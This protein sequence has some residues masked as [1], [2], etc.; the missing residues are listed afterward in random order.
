MRYIRLLH[1]NHYD[2]RKRRFKSLAFKNSNQ[3]GI[4]VISQCCIEQLNSKICDHVTTYYK[5]VTGTPAIFWIFSKQILSSNCT[6]VQQ[7]TNTGDTCHYN[8]MGLS[9]REAKN[10]FIKISLEEFQICDN[11]G[12]SRVLTLS[13][14]QDSIA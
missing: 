1:K 12:N 3:T 14:L 7:N 2:S 13:D 11:I 5:T 4:S 9:D 10:I 8:I 6:L